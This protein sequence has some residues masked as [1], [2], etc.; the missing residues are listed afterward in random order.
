[1]CPYRGFRVVGLKIADTER[2]SLNRIEFGSG[3]SCIVI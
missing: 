3:L 2:E 1:M